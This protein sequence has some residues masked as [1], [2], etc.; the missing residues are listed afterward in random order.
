MSEVLGTQICGSR[1]SEIGKSPGPTGWKIWWGNLTKI[2]RR[3]AKRGQLKY[4]I[5]REPDHMGKSGRES[6]MVLKIA[7]NIKDWA[8]YGS[9]YLVFPVRNRYKQ[10]LIWNSV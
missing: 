3:E 10:K 6:A 9:F 2:H 4:R 1:L 7:E 8:R 5:P